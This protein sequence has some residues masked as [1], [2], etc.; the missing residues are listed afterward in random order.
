MIGGSESALRQLWVG[1]ELSKRFVCPLVG[2]VSLDAS[3]NDIEELRNLEWRVF[4]HLT[5]FIMSS[6]KIADPTIL[7]KL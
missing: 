6:N 1:S 5:Q 3:S 4:N 2:L 7:D